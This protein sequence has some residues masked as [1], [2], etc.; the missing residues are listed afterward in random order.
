MKHGFRKRVEKLNRWLAQEFGQ[1]IEG[2]PRFKWVW[3]EDQDFYRSKRSFIENEAGKIQAE[4]ETVIPKPGETLVIWIGSERREV[5]ATVAYTRPVF[6]RQKV[7]DLNHCYVMCRWMSNESFLEFSDQFGGM[8]EWTPGSYF[9]VSAPNCPV[10]MKPNHEPTLDD[11][12]EFARI[13]K[14]DVAGGMEAVAE[15]LEKALKAKDQRN[16]ERAAKT[17]DPV[18]PRFD[19]IPGKRG[20]GGIWAPNPNLE[21]FRPE[22][23]GLGGSMMMNKASEGPITESQL[24]SVGV[25]TMAAVGKGTKTEIS[26]D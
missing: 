3:S 10:Q 5:Q 2:F 22:D 24:A 25:I 26:P 23:Y 20:S 21:I 9:P 7:M 14:S 6:V 18:L 8:L 19:N 1:T 17:I 16:F 13:H 15:R 11:T 4:Y 12:Q